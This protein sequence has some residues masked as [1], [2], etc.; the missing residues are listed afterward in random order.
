MGLKPFIPGWLT[1]LFIDYSGQGMGFTLTQVN[2]DN[3]NKKRLIC[4]DST[5]LTPSQERYSRVYGEHCALVWSILRYQYWLKGCKQF[6]VLSDQKALSDIYNTKGTR[7]LSDFPEELRNLSEA[8]MKY[9]FTVK[10]ILGK[11]NILADFLSHHPHWSSTQPIVK[12]TWGKD[13]PVEAIAWLAT[14]TRY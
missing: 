12:D 14:L 10:Y 7:E 1:Q 6:E 5:K 13:T 11:S 8:M 9:N 3:P 2:K 4:M